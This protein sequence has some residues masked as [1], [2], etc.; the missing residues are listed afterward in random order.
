MA[1]GRHRRPKDGSTI[2]QAHGAEQSRS[3]SSP[4]AVPIRSRWKT[5][6]GFPLNSLSRARPR[7]DARY[8][9]TNHVLGKMR[10]YGLSE[11]RVLRVVNSPKRTEKGVA[12]G[13][14]A[15]MQPGTGKRREEI[16]VMYQELGKNKELGI[17][18][19]EGR[20]ERSPRSLIHNSK[21]LIQVKKRIITAWRYP[22]VSKPHDSI[23]MP[24]DIFED[25][26]NLL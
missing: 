4:R 7:D 9:W 8:Q 19:K 26:A 5:K 1:F 13:T 2:R 3:I 20:R 15:V 22:G 17:K 10:Y 12:P 23:P 18:N 16:W 24:A 25:I 6:Q 21:S 11:G 14:I